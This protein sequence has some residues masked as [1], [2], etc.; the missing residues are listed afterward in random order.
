MVEATTAPATTAAQG[1]TEK[2]TQ[3]PTTAQPTTKAKVYVT[4]KFINYDGTQ[5]S[6]QKVEVGKSAKAPADPVKPS[7]DYYDYVF[8]G[9]QLDFSKVYSD[10][11]IAPN[12]EP[13]LKQQATDAP[14]EEVAAE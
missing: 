13:V 4:V 7:D 10:M 12:F 1:N 11:T 5:I 6:E 9:W 3:Q 2:P 14:A 8:K